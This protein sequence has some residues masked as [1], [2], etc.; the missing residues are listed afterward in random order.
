MFSSWISLDVKHQSINQSTNKTIEL[1]YTQWRTWLMV[2]LMR[3]E[4]LT[5]QSIQS[6]YLLFLMFTFVRRGGLV[7]DM[8]FNATFNNISVISW[9]SPP[10]SFQENVLLLCVFCLWSWYYGSWIY[11]CLFNQFLLPITLWIRISLGR[12]VL[13]TTLCDKV[14]Q[15]LAAGGGYIW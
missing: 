14:C 7:R 3:Q 2:Y 5:L 15:W 13:D 1:E 11:S 12:G 10:Q 9:R 6:Y 4:I 8:V